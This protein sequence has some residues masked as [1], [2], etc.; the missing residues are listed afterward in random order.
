MKVVNG[1]CGKFAKPG[2]RSKTTNKRAGTILSFRLL[3]STLN[4]QPFTSPGCWCWFIE[5][6][7]SSVFNPWL[8][9]FCDEANP[10]ARIFLIRPG[11]QRRLENIPVFGR[12]KFY[13]FSALDSEGEFNEHQPD[14]RATMKHNPFQ[15]IYR[16]DFEVLEQRIGHTSYYPHNEQLPL[17]LRAINLE[18]HG[19]LPATSPA[20]TSAPTASTRSCAGTRP[21]CIAPC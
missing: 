15:S 5:I 10:S 8:K 7:A 9:S 17:L 6:R 18:F 4:F 19:G 11:R 14:A 2:L 3:L 12:L 20:W 1:Q 16:E 13:F 21:C